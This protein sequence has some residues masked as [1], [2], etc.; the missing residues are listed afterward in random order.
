MRVGFVGLG[1]MGAG[2]AGHLATSEHDLAVY[3]VR[4]DQVDLLAST[5][6]RAATSAADA[7]A[8]ADLVSVVVL[9]DSQVLE[10]VTGPD[11]ALG[12][13][14]A[15]SVL[16]IHSTVTLACIRAVADAAQDAGVQVLDAGISGGVPGAN[17]GTLMVIAGGS[18]E[19]VEAARPG[20]APWSSEIVHVGPL[21]AGMVAKVARNYVQYAAFALVHDA[22]TLAAARDV[23]LGQLAHII[24]STK[25]LELTSIVLDRADSTPRAPEELGDAGAGIVEMI[26]LGFKDLDVAEAI[27]A[28][29][30]VDLPG[31]SSARAGFGPS[32][33]VDLRT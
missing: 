3:D 19:A 30:G 31:L 11:G 7:A 21:G 17:A 12:A 22:Q 5:G 25:A 23:D 2:M 16:A 28:E 13:M 27:A 32:I 15:G 8:G 1:K 26:R 33:G 6:A 9:D 4:T 10:V 14:P 20:L 24:R 29:L 18:P